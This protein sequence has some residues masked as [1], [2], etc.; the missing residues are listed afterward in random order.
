MSDHHHNVLLLGFTDREECRRAYE[1][2]M[3][4]PGLRQVAVLERDAEGIVDIPESH[5]RGAGV[6]TVGS[7][8]V[9]GLVGL[10]GGPIG[11]LLGF[12]AGA[13]IGNAAEQ[14]EM[15]DGGAGLIVL[16]SRVDNGRALLVADLVE[17]E[18]GPADELAA[19]YGASVER[20]SAEQFAEQVRIAKERTPED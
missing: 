18:S 8:L 10:L 1:D 3:H 5:I 17:H 7:G 6:P 12:A 4:L 14:T 11:V 2:A 16:S 19:K 20:I 15:T 13:A 9:G